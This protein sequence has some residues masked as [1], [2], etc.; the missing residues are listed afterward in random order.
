MKTEDFKA[1]ETDEKGK[2]K[3][4]TELG[5]IKADIEK[6]EKNI[7]SLNERLNKEIERLMGA[8]S[9]LMLKSL[10]NDYAN[11]KVEYL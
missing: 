1:A 4:I 11:R 5:I 3:L 7:K 2:A 9:V 6:N 8:N 10:L